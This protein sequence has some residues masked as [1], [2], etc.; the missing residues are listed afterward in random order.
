M[1]KKVEDLK[2][3]ANAIAIGSAEAAL[4]QEAEQ[5]QQQVMT[6]DILPVEMSVEG[7]KE[8]L[9]RR[10]VRFLGAVEND[11]LFQRAELPTGWKKIPAHHPWLSVLKDDRGRELARIFYK[12]E[13]Y[14]RKAEL[15]LA[16]RYSVVS[17]VGEM[18]TVSILSYEGPIFAMATDGCSVTGKGK[19]LFKTE[20]IPHIENKLER[21]KVYSRAMTEARAWL[22]SRYPG[23][24]TDPLA[25]W[26]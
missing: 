16:C 10:G 22:D 5:G 13:H 12:A 14:D 19:V 17:C 6:S 24:S 15:I 21:Y 23:W 26:D 3:L 11:P 9:E 20:E 7:A 4:R 18:S 8:F 2:F 1:D 25:Y